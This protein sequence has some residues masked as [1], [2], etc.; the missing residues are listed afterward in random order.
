MAEP[1]NTT[2]TPAPSAT[3]PAEPAAPTPAAPAAP[4]AP[5]PGSDPFAGLELSAEDRAT[6]QGILQ[7]GPKDVWEILKAKREANAEGKALRLA[8]EKADALFPKPENHPGDWDPI[9][10]ALEQVA[11]AQGATEKLVEVEGRARKAEF[12][13]GVL[14]KAA[15]HGQVAHPEFLIFQAEQAAAATPQGQSFDVGAWLEQNRGGTLTPAFGKP[16]TPPATSGRP[17]G[18]PQGE[19][20]TDEQKIARLQKEGKFQ[21]AFK[22]ARQLNL[23]HNAAA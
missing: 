16:A 4:A 19:G 17:D 3:A 8:R 14:E 15:A 7:G 12:R 1:A 23:K 6:V 10:K 5:Q 21:E 18:G 11:T 13:A 9:G 20:E 22:I 2:T